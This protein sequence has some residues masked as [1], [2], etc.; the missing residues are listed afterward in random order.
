MNSFQSKKMIILNCVKF[1]V[2]RI[3][4]L[5]FN[6]ALTLSAT[7]G[8]S[9]LDQAKSKTRDIYRDLSEIKEIQ[10]RHHS[11]NDV[12]CYFKDNR[13]KTIECILTDND[14]E[15]GWK[16]GIKVNYQTSKLEFISLKKLSHKI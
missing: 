1:F 11:K 12:D 15:L 9:V 14:K 5:A 2:M 7:F 10:I 3:L 6:F 8:S 13:Q 4:L 16:Q